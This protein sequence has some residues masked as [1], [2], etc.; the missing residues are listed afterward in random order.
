MPEYAM[1]GIVVFDD[2]DLNPVALLTNIGEIRWQLDNNL[3]VVVEDMSDK[4]PPLS[5]SSPDHIYVQP[6]DDLGFSGTI[7]YEKS[8]AQLIALPSQGLEVTV[9][10][11]YGSELLSAY[12]EVNTGG[13]WSSGMVLPSR[14]LTDD[15]L[16]VDYSITGVISPGSD[17]T[18][19]ETLVTV[20]DLS[21]IHI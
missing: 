19:A 11:T 15:L 1:P 10:T 17:M 14:A 8:G 9:S 2:D 21:L 20:D 3:Q 6:G 7:I 12:S 18:D 4:S 5:Q 16:V 13:L